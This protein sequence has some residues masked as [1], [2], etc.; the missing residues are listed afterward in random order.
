MTQF[1]CC[2]IDL[3]SSEC[4]NT[5]FGVQV[6]HIFRHRQLRTLGYIFLI[7]LVNP[8]CFSR[9]KICKPIFLAPSRLLALK[10]VG[11]ILSYGALF[12]FEGKRFFQVGKAWYPT[13]LSVTSLLIARDS[14]AC[15]LHLPRKP[16]LLLRSLLYPCQSNV[17]SRR[18]DSPESA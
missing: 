9:Q 4:L 13:D 11:W 7:Q 18:L 5:R 12:L 8:G 16:V 1:I 2:I 3:P 6:E 14:K 17:S 10:W 15:F